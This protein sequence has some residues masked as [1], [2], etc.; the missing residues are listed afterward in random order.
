M[1]CFVLRNSSVSI[2]KAIQEWEKTNRILEMSKSDHK[3]FIFIHR[4]KVYEYMNGY[5]LT[6]STNQFER[7]EKEH[8]PRTPSATS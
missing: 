1:P 6:A 3:Y 8:D 4:N 2:E 7:M 5:G